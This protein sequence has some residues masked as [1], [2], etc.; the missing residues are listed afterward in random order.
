MGMAKYLT[1]L[2]TMRMTAAELAELRD[3]AKFKYEET[4]AA[5]EET[6]AAGGFYWRSKYTASDLVRALVKE[7]RQRQKA[8]GVG[9]AVLFELVR[10]E[11]ATREHG[12][13][14]TVGGATEEHARALAV[15][16]GRLP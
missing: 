5:D 14:F 11:D 10:T 6:R 2:F 8:K 16:F 7:E 3:L 9:R 12:M 15:A 13:V 1:K 4:R